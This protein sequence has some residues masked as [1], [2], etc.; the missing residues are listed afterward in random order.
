MKTTRITGK[1]LSLGRFE[2]QIVDVLL[3]GTVMFFSL[4]T[5]LFHWRISNPVIILILNILTMG[6][7]LGCIRW[8]R[9][10]SSPLAFFLI[11]TASVQLMFFYLFG[12]V[13]RMQLILHTHWKDPIVLDL[14]HSLFGI[15]PTIWLQQVVHP[16]LTEW[17]MFAYVM[18]I[19]IYPLLAALIYFRFGKKQLEDYFFVLGLTNV[20]CFLGFM[21]FPVASPMYWMAD[22][23][24]VPLKGYVFTGIGEFIRS[25]LHTIGGSIP[26]PHSAI[27]TVMWLMAYR[28]HRG[29]FYLITP[30][31]ISLYLS[32]FYCRY[33]YVTDT[34]IGI[35]TGVLVLWLSK[36]MTGLWNR[37][38]SRKGEIPTKR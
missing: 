34:V 27:A 37:F 17:F 13:E 31:I 18:Y 6:L 11:R 4:T 12:I 32:T 10:L 35:I 33:H 21:V 1:E 28:Y 8:S 29:F 38:I 24:T 19:P 15:Q 5:V 30:V 23:F 36:H 2:F 7:Y 22:K 16:A 3:I 9:K 20:V 26:S 25:Y 14:E